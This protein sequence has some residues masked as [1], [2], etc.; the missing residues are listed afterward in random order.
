MKAQLTY[1]IRLGAKAHGRASLPV[2]ASHVCLERL[3]ARPI[4]L[5]ILLTTLLGST[6]LSALTLEEQREQFSTGWA[7]ASRADQAATLDALQAMGEYPLRPYLEFELLRQRIDRVPEVVM[8]QFLARH[9]DW[10][11]ARSLE[12][13]WLVSLA[14]RGDYAALRRHAGASTDPIVQCH[15]ARADLDEG[16]MEGLA[17]RVAELWTVGSS[18]PDDCNPLFDWW[19]R[20]NHLRPEL[21]WTRF[22]LALGA[23]DAGLARYLRRYLDRD[24]NFWAERWLALDQRPWP[25]LREARQWPDHPQAQRMIAGRLQDLAASDWERA[26]DSWQ[27][28][29]PVFDFS[30]HER[31]VVARR[32]AL[33][34]AVDLD[35]DAIAAIDAL[36][37]EQ[38]DQQMLEWRTRV[39]LAHGR[40]AEVLASIAAMSVVEQAHSRW[41]YWRGRALAALNRPEALLAYGSLSGESSYYGFLAAQ[42]LGQD[43]ALCSE[44]LAA[45]AAVQRRLMRDAEF[46]RALE[47]YQV[48]LNWHGRW[49]WQR[50]T[51]RLSREELHQA[52]LLAAGQGWHD[53]AIAALG[54]A[55]TLGA[56]PW[57]FPLIDR[58]RVLGQAARYQVEPA[59]VYGLMRA[60]S[61]LQPDALSPAGARGLLQ[62]MPS[63][64]SQVARRHGLSYTG[65]ASLMRPDVNVP[66]GVAHLG[67]L[68]ERYDGRWIHVAAAYNAGAG[69]VERWLDSRPMSDADIWLETLP[70][71][72]TRDYVPRVLA[73][74]TIYEWQLGQSPRVL[75][76]QIG[77]GRAGASGGFTCAP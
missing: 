53:R 7:A 14:R 11:F 26:R 34:Q 42:A 10:S 27:Q 74:A 54:K 32:L 71:Y 75:A 73:F 68:Q 45:D 4:V 40:W 50:V 62:L 25:T 23:G 61:A 48:G 66:L 60:E 41:R 21:A 2:R 69:A 37:S 52:A 8:D 47:L 51:G 39:A 43:L 67:E 6:A 22:Q 65:P 28:L 59:L 49:T 36:P 70:F 30:D 15:L 56:Y 29:E 5:T 44:E 76:E 31:A 17:E 9:R 20:N 58:S 1:L 55:G 24:Q 63:T 38:I 19:R 16:R 13:Q 35:L 3:M 77:V 64:A 72:E 46:E 33:F 57:R 18:R 12:R